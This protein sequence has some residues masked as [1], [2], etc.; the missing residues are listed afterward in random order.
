MWDRGEIS[1]DAIGD[2]VKFDNL[3]WYDI[4]EDGDLDVITTE[5][6]EPM[7]DGPGPGL[8]VIWYEN[9]MNP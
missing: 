9:P 5:Q 1:G 8:G 6:N 3:I 2:G 7:V 4:D